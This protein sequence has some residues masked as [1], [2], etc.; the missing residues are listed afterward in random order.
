MSR[1]GEN[2][3]SRAPYISSLVGSEHDL[4]RKMN[5]PS[6]SDNQFAEHYRSY[7]NLDSAMFQN[8][9]NEVRKQFGAPGSQQR[10]SIPMGGGR[11]YAN[12]QYMKRRTRY[13]NES[14]ARRKQ[15][16][17]YQQNRNEAAASRRAAQ[18]EQAS[19]AQAQKRA[20][21]IQAEQQRK[22]QMVQQGR[23]YGNFVQNARVP[24]RSSQ[25]YYKPPA[26]S[27]SPMGSSFRQAMMRGFSPPPRQ[28]PPSRNSSQG[29]SNTPP[30]RQRQRSA[31]TNSPSNYFNNRFS[32]SSIP[33][34]SSR[35]GR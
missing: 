16:Q 8:R 7:Q 30:A 1:Y 5:N 31:D 9:M 22:Q 4:R 24:Q 6:I 25:G 18:Q 14:A 26:R 28:A 32:N 12:N 29:Y 21:G 13:G 3:N 33:S 20:L 35:R 11:N 10:L 2:Y 17:Q 15:M 27:S 34:Y 23:S 19:Q